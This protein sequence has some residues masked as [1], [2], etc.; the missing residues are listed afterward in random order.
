MNSF[1]ITDAVTSKAKAK[2][3]IA[4]FLNPELIKDGR[5]GYNEQAYAHDNLVRAFKMNT[6]LVTPPAYVKDIKYIEPSTETTE[7]GLVKSYVERVLS[8]LG[9]SFLMSSDGT[10]GTVAKIAL[11]Q[12]MKM[13]N[14]ITE[15]LEFIMERLYRNL[16]I[17]NGFDS[18]YSPSVQIMDSELMEH[19][20]KLEFAKVLF[21]TF[22]CSMETAL[23]ILGIDFNDELSKR[24]IE[25]EKGVDGIFT[26]HA[27]QY[28]SS[29]N[30]G[31]RPANDDVENVDKQEYDNNRNNDS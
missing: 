7:P 11:D 10:N 19:D 21:S 13:I 30:D 3:I 22:N 2:K 8:T 14:S 24:K 5:N 1:D 9:I 26:P 23:S 28:T 25:N 16:L 4:Q 29:G 20:M 18:I 6:V 27:S 17:E 12:L 15:N 31:G